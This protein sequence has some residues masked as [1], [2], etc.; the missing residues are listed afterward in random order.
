MEKVLFDHRRMYLGKKKIEQAAATPAMVWHI[1]EAAAFGDDLTRK[2]Y[3]AYELG[4][5]RDAAT[6]EALATMAD[7]LQPQAEA[8]VKQAAAAA[9]TARKLAARVAALKPA[10]VPAWDSPRPAEPNVPSD[11]D[12]LL[13]LASAA[14]AGTSP[15]PNRAAAC[16]LELAGRLGHMADL[17]RWL[18]LNCRFFHEDNVWAKEPG[19]APRT[20]CYSLQ[21]RVNEVGTIQSRIE[22]MLVATPAER[23]LW[24]CV[25]SPWTSAGPRAAALRE[26]TV[27]GLPAMREQIAAWRKEEVEIDRR[28][29][30]LSHERKISES[31]AIRT[32]ELIP[33][34]VRLEYAQREA[35][36]VEW[37][38]SARAGG[39]LVTEEQ[40]GPLSLTARAGLAK[41]VAVFDPAA[42]KSLAPVLADILRRPYLASVADVCLYQSAVLATEPF[43]AQRI[44]RWLAITPAPDVRGLMDILH[45][46]PGVMTAGERSDNAYQPKIMEWA[47]RCRGKDATARFEQAHALTNE[48]YKACG[49][50]LDKPVYGLRDVLESRLVDCIAASRIQGAVAAAAG[51]TGIVPVRLWRAQG[52]HSI[53]GLRTA[54]G[55]V[56]MDP[57]TGPT[58]WTFPGGYTGGMTVETG[59]PTLGTYVTDA[60]EIIGKSKVLR[61]QLPY[62]EV[63]K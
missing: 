9:E 6:L 57:L 42:R 36:L 59:A 15:D 27:K 56:I 24:A 45:P 2:F 17:D 23:E 22:D 44:N 5:K 34:M 46:T 60:V 38:G 31:R 18:A 11:A 49:Y 25:T 54:K 8:L 1:G 55:I 39:L 61:R 52:G 47:A 19:M 41:I 43:L 4:A 13:D 48:F 37:G 28:A 14:L 50:N 32:K 7:Q 29:A 16:L 53:I 63:A 30:A 20:L 26:E 10:D 3:P 40:A 35:S 33:V 62:M 58:K 51:V 21:V 12:V